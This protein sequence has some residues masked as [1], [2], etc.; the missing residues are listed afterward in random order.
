VA[1]ALELSA[2]KTLIL[3]VGF[4]APDLP[5]ELGENLYELKKGGRDL[6]AAFIGEKFEGLHNVFHN[7]L[8]PKLKSPHMRFVI[9]DWERLCPVRSDGFEGVMSFALG[10]L[11]NAWGAGVY[12]FDDREL[13]G[14][15]ISARDLSDFYDRLTEEIGVSGASDDL[16]PFFGPAEGLLPPVELDQTSAELLRRYE[17]KRARLRREGI[18]VGRP[19]L[20]LLTERRGTREAY[21]YRGLEFFKPNIPAVYNSSYTLAKLA[22]RPNVKYSPGY[23][24]ERYEEGP[25]GVRVFARN[26]RTREVEGFA[27]RKLALGAGTISTSKIVLA[28]HGDFE[29]RLPLLDNAISYTP[30]VSPRL[31]GAAQEKRFFAGVQLNVIHSP[32]GGGPT[33]QGSFYGPTGIMRSDLL[34]EMPLSAKGN[35]AAVKYLTPALGILQLF[36]PDR[37]R[38]SNYLKLSRGGEVEIHYEAKALGTV[39][40]RFISAFRKLGYYSLPS[41]CKYPAPGNSFHYAGTLPMRAEPRGRYETGPDGKLSGAAHVYVVDAANFSA[42]PSKNHTFT[43]MANSMRVASHIG[44]ALRA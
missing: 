3:D 16:T 24:V 7:Y 23:L 27:A 12:R 38:Q 15:P 21:D 43:I 10:G 14:F 11:S 19:R 2:A 5:H 29:T 8:S 9:Q 17:K 26:L 36:Y 37:P 44:R 41:L 6:S 20:A 34:G 42:L 33:I 13:E 32:G 4:R 35:L 1:A 40:R 30:Y 31:I 18:Y 22:E 39:E 28:S 25:E